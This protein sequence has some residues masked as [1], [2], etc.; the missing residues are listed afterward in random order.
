[1]DINFLNIRSYDGSQNNGFEELIC[2]LA[3]LQKPNEAKAFVR[4]EGAGGDAGVECYWVLN[5]G[6][7]IGWQAK[8]FIGE[9]SSSRWSQID[10]SFKTALKKHPNLKKYIVCLPL[11]RT[12]SRKMGRGGDQVVSVLDEWNDKVKSWE[13][14]AAEKGRTIEF[15]FWGKH[16]LTQFLTIDDPLYAGRALY[17][18]N[19]PVLGLDV[20][21]SITLKSKD[22]LGDRYTP[23]S[24]IDL[25]VAENFDA[26][27]TS[28]KWWKKLKEKNG[29]L[30]DQHGQFSNKFGNKEAAALQ[31]WFLEKEWV[32]SLES[33]SLKIINLINDSLKNRNF[34]QN[35]GQMK[36]L[37][38]ELLKHEGEIV[39]DENGDIT[40][41]RRQFSG[42][43]SVIQ[44]L[45]YSY[46][47]FARFLDSKLIKVAVIRAALLH[48]EAGIG[49]SHLLCDL[50]LRRIDENH[51]TV[52]LLGQHYE[53]G[54]PLDTLRSSLDLSKC[55]NA[56]VLGALDAAGEA[57]KGR[58]LIIVDAINEGLHR[59]DWQNHIRAFLTE[60]SKYPNISVLLSCRTSYLDYMI[61]ESADED[62]LIRIQHFGFQG[63]EHRAAEKYM[64]K[65]G[66]SKPSAPILAP[67]FT[68]PL[69]LK[70][71][72]Q[73]LK[74][75]E[76]TSFP[77]GM[78]GLTQLFEFFL[79]SVE[80]TVAKRKRY[81]PSEQIIK[82]ALKDFAS[83]LF[84]NNFSGLPTGDA[85]KL[86]NPHDPNGSKGE[87]LFDELLYEG[88]LS[89]DISY[90][91]KG[92]GYP[93]V[94]FTYERFSDHF[95]AQQIVGQYDENTIKGIFSEDEPMGKLLTER[96]IHRYEGIFEALSIVLAEQYRLELADMLP[97]DFDGFRDGWVL[98]R[99]FT[100]TI[101]WRSPDSFTDRTLEILN[102]LRGHEFSSPAIDTLLK[103]STEP[104]HPWNADLLHKNLV[105]KS[106][107]E[108][109]HFWSIQIAL[110]DQ[111]EEDGEAETIV[112]TLIEWSC[113]GDI[114]DIEKERARL[115]AITLFWLLTTSNRK[116]RDQAT[117]S[118][119]RLLSVHP[120]LLPNLLKQ[121]HSINDLYLVERLYAVA[122]GVA[123]NI[124]DNPLIS[125]IAGTVFALVFKDGEPI[126]HVLLRDYARGVL[127]YALHLEVLPE[128]IDPEQFRPPYKSEWPID[129][130]SKQD[131]DQIDGDE[132][133]SHIKSSLMGFPGDFGNYTM[134]CIH[135]WS[136]T[137][138]SEP[139]PKTGYDY[140]KEFAEKFFEGELKDQYLEK[141]KP[142][143]KEPFDPA[144]LEAARKRV[145]IMRDKDLMKLVQQNREDEQKKESAFKDELT[146]TLDEDQK[147]Y[148]RWLT[149][150]SNDRPAA[151]SR[152]WA[153][154]WVC[155]RAHELGWKEKLFKG[156]EE[157]CSY[158]RDA[159]RGEGY[160]ERI[161][162]K[163]QW[164]ALHELLARLSDNVHWIDRG[165]SDIEDETYYG[166]WQMHKRN[167]DPTI[168]IRG[169]AERDSYY[170]EQTK[171]W[172]S[173][174]FPLDNFTDVDA[175]LK[176]MWSESDIP[177]SSKIVS[178]LD[179]YQSK[180]WLALR[181]FWMQIQNE[182][183]EKGMPR[184]D[185]W[186][187]IN[188]IIIQKGDFEKIRES[189]G[190]KNLIDPHTVNVPSTQHQGY[191]GEYPWHPSCRFMA[192]WVDNTEDPWERDIKGKYLVP[193]SQY[194]WENGSPDYSLDSSLSLY[195]PAGEIIQGMGLKRS[196]EN[197]GAWCN[198]K[199]EIVFQDPSIVEG[200]PS[201][202]LVQKEAFLN[203]LDENDLEILWLIGGEKQLFKPSSDFFGRLVYNTLCRIENKQINTDVWFE[204]QGSAEP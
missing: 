100:Q 48:G 124:D 7:E 99:I 122:Y 32:D 82:T 204:R 129:N 54:N 20:F 86:I 3:H 110:G 11:D 62:C 199:G 38:E 47:E 109:D 49:K 178:M 157:R 73:A 24:H 42:E 51:P 4:K 55:T 191:I 26:L 16:E 103:L 80:K 123:C 150:L 196:M 132:F 160:M 201:F 29:K 169:D 84:P 186:F 159:G 59:D 34:L 119:V 194:E 5:D 87:S 189:I 158:G 165:Y 181:G 148:F 126:P 92:E 162:K 77:K 56:Q 94:R 114:K 22:S 118:L 46:R 89:E 53:G 113:F 88:I 134:S 163:Y 166:P 14:L 116:V 111:F 85:R 131:I 198:S 28:A 68:N 142:V 202:A 145:E 153:Q 23:E 188:S 147:E 185:A 63:Y 101:L 67:E 107:A 108:R 65:Q 43:F 52:F 83:S 156:F 149:G 172:Q 57:H 75:N 146:K 60:I 171:W 74:E 173:Y 36:A 174:K 58:T 76:M 180:D 161:G 61:P 44:S 10:E 182:D 136:P 64:S 18:L 200:G 144:D 50:S 152:K 190:N 128:G 35:L 79:E 102:M 168:W 1:M 183:E 155:V 117:K 154:R 115:C 193:V 2:Q 15:E 151:F 177:D 203:W 17:W 12:D 31:E 143:K 25:P 91:D 27:G 41:I 30:K 125:K 176:F 105:D 78:H 93:V 138:L 21:K 45:F 97:E 127:E 66:I 6:S 139:A 106:M 130:P 120:K 81:N 133:S 8:F 184:L 98:E 71:C 175:Q 170:N 37:C 187:R 13:V 39:Q 104:N 192:G 195:M 72:C 33:I 137:P 19:E 121:F 9:I 96:G 40:E 112:R 141:N 135:E 197:F 69:F 164:I 95:I 70:T 90:N 140:K 179:P 167:I